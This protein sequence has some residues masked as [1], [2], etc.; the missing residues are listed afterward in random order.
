MPERVDAFV[1]FG[2]FPRELVKIEKMGVP[3]AHRTLVLLEPSVT[4]PTLHSQAYVGQFGAVFAASPLWSQVVG[5]EPFFW[6]QNLRREPVPSLDIA[7]ATLLNS[8][9]R[10]AST[11]SLYGLRRSVILAAGRSGKRLIVAGSGWNTGPIRVMRRLKEAASASIK[12]ISAGQRPDVLEAWGGIGISPRLCIGP[13]PTKAMALQYAPVSIV[14]E[15]SADYVSEKLVD[16][17]RHGVAPIYVGPDLRKFG[18]PDSIAIPVQP[19]AQCVLDTL[20]QLTRS[21]IEDVIAAG[22]HWLES[23]DAE[24]HDSERIQQCL[25][26]RVMEAN[27]LS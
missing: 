25:A 17:V 14:I 4:S 2:Y 10:S 18:I 12:S 24:M 11:E 26:V 5:A 7:D 9:K 1:A 21:E 19:S 23:T 8:E 16:V 22:R 3:R 15:N 13:V 6:P 27:N 20:G